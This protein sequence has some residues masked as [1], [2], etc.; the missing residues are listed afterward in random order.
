[1]KHYMILTALILIANL[2]MAQSLTVLDNDDTDITD[3]TIVINAEPSEGELSLDYKVQNLTGHALTAKVD[4]ITVQEVPNTFNTYCVPDVCVDY[5][6]NTSPEFDVN[7]NATVD[8]FS[9][10]YYPQGNEGI[11]IIKYDVY[12]IANPSDS[13]SFTIEYNTTTDIESFFSLN[14][15]SEPYPNPASDFTR[16]DY[17]LKSDFSADVRLY[18]LS[19]RLI[20]VFPIHGD[21]SLQIPV[22]ALDAGIYFLRFKQ[23]IHSKVSKLIVQ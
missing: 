17:H 20:D 12:N 16:I 22:D 15:I 18:S 5:G 13:A 8:G 4:K 9:V 7:P 11:T 10:H 6:T 2:G 3:S 1:M 23:G 19:G 14:L 21:S